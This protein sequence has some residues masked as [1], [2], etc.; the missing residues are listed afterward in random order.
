MQKAE[1]LASLTSRNEDS[2]PISRYETYET[3]ASL[4]A[5][6]DKNT[7]VTKSL[8]LETLNPKRRPAVDVS[9]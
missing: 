9:R 7:L 8:A 6:E 1:E 3:Q 2:N 5:I 4:P